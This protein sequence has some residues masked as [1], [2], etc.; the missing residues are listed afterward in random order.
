MGAFQEIGMIAHLSN[1]P[2]RILCDLQNFSNQPRV[3][4]ASMLKAIWT[5]NIQCLHASASCDFQKLTT[6][7]AEEWT[8]DSQHSL[9]SFTR[10]TGSTKRDVLIS[11]TGITFPVG[12]LLA[13][14]TQSY[15][16]TFCGGD[17]CAIFFSCG[18]SAR[19]LSTYTQVK[20]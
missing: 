14:N 9:S 19:L 10:R 12:D 13:R 1:L 11:S 8:G 15:T 16:F 3:N 7:I 20:R 18:Q 17:K 5:Q 6:Y 4:E 2:Y